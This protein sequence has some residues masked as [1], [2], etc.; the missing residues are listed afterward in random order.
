ME[1]RVQSIKFNVDQKLLDF[2]DKQSLAALSWKRRM[3]VRRT[4]CFQTVIRL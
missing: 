3:L 1:I 4:I 2:I